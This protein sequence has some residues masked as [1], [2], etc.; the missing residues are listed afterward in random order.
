M[1]GPGIGRDFQD[2]ISITE[3]CLRSEQLRISC[4]S[5]NLEGRYGLLPGVEPGLAIFSKLYH[6]GT[7]GI[8]HTYL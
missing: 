4:Y 2:S 8:G 5:N 7:H 3:N 1:L 6:S